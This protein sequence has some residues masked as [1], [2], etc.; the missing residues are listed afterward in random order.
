M[1]KEQIKTNL[2]DMLQAVADEYMGFNA[3][4]YFEDHRHAFL[5]SY[6][7]S[8][9][10]E[11]N[12]AFWESI[13]AVENHF[14]NGDSSDVLF[15]FNGECFKNSLECATFV[16]KTLSSNQSEFCVSFDLPKLVEFSFKGDVT[17]DSDEFYNTPKLLLAA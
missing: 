12:D 9:S 7:V 6:T 15:S 1:D 3:K 4:V 14:D 10:L 16:W 11:E 2:I 5:V 17:H 13:L 8:P